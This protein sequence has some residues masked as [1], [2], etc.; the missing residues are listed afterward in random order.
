LAL[1]KKSGGFQKEALCHQTNHKLN[2]QTG[3]TSGGCFFA[4]ATNFG[5]DTFQ[6]Q[7]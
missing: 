7:T 3:K 5:N 4:F 2:S 6:N 1:A